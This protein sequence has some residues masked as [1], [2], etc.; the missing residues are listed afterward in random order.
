MTGAIEWIAFSAALGSG[1]IAGV[2]FAF[3]AFVMRALGRLP[4]AQGAAAM[5]EINVVVLNPAFLFVFLGTAIACAVVAIAVLAGLPPGKPSMAVAAV[6]YA[7]GTFGVTIAR[8]VPLNERLASADPNAPETVELWRNY[9]VEWTFWN[10]VRTVAA[11]A[12]LAVFLFA[13][14]N[15]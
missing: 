4:A 10:H 5:Q 14:E 6:L 9:Q 11:L 2:F 1:L 7:A 12:A 13:F 3:S 8:N 15:C